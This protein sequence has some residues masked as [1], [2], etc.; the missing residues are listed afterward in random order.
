MRANLASR[1]SIA[2]VRNAVF[3][4]DAT[5][6]LR[7][8]VTS[9]RALEGNE[10]GYLDISTG[11]YRVR[12]KG[13]LMLIHHVVWAIEHGVWPMR[14][15]HINGCKWDNRACNLR[16]CSQSENMA[17]QGIAAHNTS[18]FKGVHWSKA[19]NKWVAQIRVR[20]KNDHLGVFETKEL[21]SA[22]YEKAAKE[23]FGEFARRDSPGIER[24]HMSTK[25]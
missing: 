16:E 18:G 23:A 5:Y 21:A 13:Q 12:I 17:N 4:D 20:G 10:A 3:Y 24:T 22:A 9:G 14:V 11:Y 8:R 2:D 25:I 6:T 15:D 19:A 7:W 1:P